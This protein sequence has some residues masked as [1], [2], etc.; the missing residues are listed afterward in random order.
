MLQNKHSILHLHNINHLFTYRHQH[1]LNVSI[2]LC[3]VKGRY[4]PETSDAHFS[5]VIYSMDVSKKAS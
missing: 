4:Q 5:V 2:W 1:V 3:A